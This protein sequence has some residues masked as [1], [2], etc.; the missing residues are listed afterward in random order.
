MKKLIYKAAVLAIYST[1]FLLLPLYLFHVEAYQKLIL[2][3]RDIFF[4]IREVSSE[5]PER[6]DETLLV[7]IDDASCQK[8]DLRWPWPRTVFA[9]MIDRL[10]AAG[11]RVIA[12]NLSFTGLEGNDDQSTR[13]LARAIGARPNAVIG[14]TFDDENRLIK[15]T[16]ILAEVVGRYGYLEKIVDPD[17]C[18]R[19]SYLVRPYAKKIGFSGSD[20]FASSFALEIMAAYSGSAGQ[21]S[22]EY[23]QDLGLVTVGVAPRRAVYADSEGAYTVNYL[24]GAADFEKVSAWKIIQGGFDPALVKNKVVFVG[25]SSALL[26]DRHPTPLGLQPGMVIN[27]NEFLSMLEDRQLRFVPDWLT[28]TLSW[29]VGL[30]VIGLFLLRR[31]WLG[32]LGGTLALGGLWLG[33]QILFFRD[34]VM[35]PLPLV[36]GPTLALAAGFVEISVRL[37]WENKHLET[38]AIHDKLT[39]LYRYEYLRESLEEEWKRCVRGKLPVSIVMTDLD[40]FKA[41]NDNLGHEVGNDMIKRAAEVIRDSARRYDVVSRYGGDEFVVLLWHTNWLEAK[42]WRHRLRKAY[43][44]MASKFDHVQLRASTISIG[45]ATF[46]PS[47]DAHFPANPQSLIEEADKDLFLDKEAGRKGS[48]R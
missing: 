45:I 5:A 32:V 31:M 46:D 15:P 4:K 36:W 14:V 37:L 3:T 26:S 38:H 1:F 29:L 16:P 25:Q 28:L 18:I 35:E 41:I 21:G 33:A 34:I 30:C 7:M 39:G 48:E 24:S 27:A 2:E 47:I 22:P 44:E 6:I 9:K 42:A 13:E 19:R 10:N 40:R 23:D 8:L 43:E 11:A 17:L 20:S 12:L